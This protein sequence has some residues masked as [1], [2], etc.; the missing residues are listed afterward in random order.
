[1]LVKNWKINGTLAFLFATAMMT[2]KSTYGYNQTPKCY[3]LN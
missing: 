3:A 2:S 1:M